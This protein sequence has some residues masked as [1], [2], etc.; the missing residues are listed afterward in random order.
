M[1]PARYTPYRDVNI[2]LHRLRTDV[3]TVLGEQ[4]VGMYLYGSLSLG[5]FD[6]Q[7]SDVDFLVVTKTEL[8]DET[9]AEMQTMHRHIATSTLPFATR[10]EGSYIPQTALRRHDPAHAS[11]P[12]INSHDSPDPHEIM[13]RRE[14]HGN[15]WD[16]Q[17]HIVREHGVVI[18]GPTPT[19]LIDSI[20]PQALQAGV[21]Q[22]LYGW[23]LEILDT[24][25]LEQPDYQAF[26]ILTMCRMLYTFEYGTVVS[27][28]VAAEWALTTLEPRWQWLIQWALRYPEPP[29]QDPL[30]ETRALIR[31]VMEKGKE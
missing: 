2:I 22:L 29:P 30:T 11:H 14:S 12:Y 10:L 23:W 9:V 6:P 20:P 27:K 21:R 5:D 13:V 3:E 28:P 4:F 7:T 24:P 26:A 16:I 8:P 25:V 19:T 1:A 15:D 18:A 31:Y 17:R